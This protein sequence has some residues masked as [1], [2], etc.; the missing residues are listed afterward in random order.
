MFC[1]PPCARSANGGSQ[2]RLTCP[3][4]TWPPTQSTVGCP[5]ST[6]AA[7][8]RGSW[9]PSSCAAGLEMTTHWVWRRLARCSLNAAWTAFLLGARTPGGVTCSSRSRHRRR[10]CHPGL[11]PPCWP[12]SAV[13]ALRSAELNQTSIYYAGG[14]F[15]LTPGAPRCTRTSPGRQPHEAPPTPSPMPFINPSTS[16][17][18]WSGPP[19]RCK[20]LSEKVGV[21]GEEY[22]E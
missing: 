18:P 13:D 1:C 7:R 4:N 8:R 19:V 16:T 11:S 2:V 6:K 17:A 14:A 20:S 21:I 3:T 15:R 12:A 10:R 5:N 9:D 22:V